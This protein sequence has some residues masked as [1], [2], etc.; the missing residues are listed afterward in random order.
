[1]NIGEYLPRRSRGKYSPIFNIAPIFNIPS[2]P[3]FTEPEENN[4]FSKI[5]QVNI[6]ETEKRK[7]FK[8]IYWRQVTKS[9]GKC[10]RWGYI[11]RAVTIAK[12]NKILNQ[13]T[14]VKL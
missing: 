7:T 14:S 4:C 12:Y 11:Y 2:S 5:T 6:R 13:S 3:I 1:V 10:S 9:N 8:R